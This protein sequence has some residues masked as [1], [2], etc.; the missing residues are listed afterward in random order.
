MLKSTLINIVL[1]GLI[2]FS[3]VSFAN[4]QRPDYSLPLKVNF[5][6]LTPKAQQEVRCLAD[7]IFYESAKE[8]EQGKIAVAFVT[9][10]RVK[11]GQFPGTVCEVVKQKTQNVCQFSWYC[12]ADARS[13]ALTKRLP[14]LYNDILKLATEVYINHDKMKDPSRGALFYHADYVNPQWPNMRRTIVIGR[15]IFYNKAKRSLS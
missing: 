5:S 11:S 9:L 14:T 6:Q 10:N 13:K 12:E 8:P 4:R 2:I 15:H 1:L 7:N 3:S